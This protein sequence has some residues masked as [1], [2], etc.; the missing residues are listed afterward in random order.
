MC[1][2]SI[3]HVPIRLYKA[4]RHGVQFPSMADS[5]PNPAD[6]P[7]DA[8]QLLHRAS[9][10]D[11]AAVDDLLPLVYQELRARA[12]SY[13]LGQSANHTLQP[14]ALVHEAYVKLVRAPSAGWNSRAHFCAVAA[15]VMRQILT[16]HARR[17]AAAHR[18]AGERGQ[19]TTAMFTPSQNAAVDLLSLDDAMTKLGKLDSRQARIVEL[20]FFGGLTVEEVA[21][22]LD[23]STSTIE[24]EWRRVRAW[25]IR[26]LSGEAG[27]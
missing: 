11:S 9:A 3:T 18:A 24:K 6:R 20:R 16:D 23:V 25:L 22:V 1:G 5:V 4:G 14:T 17:R 13:F 8:T 19:I 27:A 15:T 10:G 12:G 7:P 21:G 2:F 26:E